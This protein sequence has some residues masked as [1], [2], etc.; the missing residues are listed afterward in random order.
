MRICYLADA[1][2]IHTQRW[3]KYF[4]EKG[5]EVYLFSYRP[6]G[7]G[8][9]KLKNV[10]LY[11]LPETRTPIRVVSYFANLLSHVRQIRKLIREIK[12]DLLHAHFV[13][14]EGFLGALTS[15]HPFVVSAWGS[16][17]LLEPKRSK[18]SKWKVRF[19]L[20]RADLITCAGEHPAARARELGADPERVKVIY[21]GVDTQEFNPQQNNGKLREELGVFDSPVIISLRNFGPIYDV[22]SL[23]KAVP[24]VLRQ[25]PNAKF[26]IA[27]DG[28]Q[29]NY[30]ENLASSLQVSD[31]VKFVG[32]IPHDEL[33]KYLTLADVYVSTSLSDGGVSVSTLEAMAC[34]LPV[35]ITDV[36]DNRMWVK[37]GENGFF[38][39]E[40]DYGKLADMVIY[41]LQNPSIRKRVGEMNRK[42][43]AENLSYETQ[44]KK[45]ERIYE[46]LIRRCQR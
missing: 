10:N 22:E 24:L 36:G 46:G 18:R 8:S 38:V 43:V 35:V 3:V 19:V 15:F 40:R 31:S 28:E 25:I 5:Y 1:E 23:V 45:M 12:P 44:M 27:G 30:L 6:F 2:S 16:D 20:K 13:S 4:V 34:Q 11:L 14:A 41:L 37:D 33:P 17:V 39:P 32:R 29:R 7:E 21:F 42:V 9:L 26:I